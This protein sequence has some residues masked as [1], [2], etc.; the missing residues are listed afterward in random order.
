MLIIDRFEGETAVVEYN[1]RTFDLPRELLPVDAK[2][3]DVI[4]LSVAVDKE[5]TKKRKQKIDNLVDDIFE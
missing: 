4:R 1:G 5:E 2:E 3:G